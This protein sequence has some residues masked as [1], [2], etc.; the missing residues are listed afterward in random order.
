MAQ[1]VKNLP[2]MQEMEPW[3]GK[4]LWEGNG[5]PV[6]YFCLENPVDRGAWWATVYRVTNSW[7]Q[8]KWLST[9]VHWV[10][11]VIQ[12]SHPLS[13]PSPPALSLSQ[14]QGL[15]QWVGS[16]HQ[17][18]KVLEYLLL[19]ILVLKNDVLLIWGSNVTEASVLP[20]EE[21]ITCPLCGPQWIVVAD[22]LL[23]RNP[24]FFQHLTQY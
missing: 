9:H 7:T 11:D 18:D 10:S 12:L 15:F 1:P 2:A 3:V 24:F 19:D 17:V 20:G 6:Q 8:L 23:F 4:I 16:S 22:R 13:T 21:H 5:N 14:H